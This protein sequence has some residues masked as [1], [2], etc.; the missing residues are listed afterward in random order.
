VSGVALSVLVLGMHRSGTSAISGALNILG[1]TVPGE[2]IPA[3]DDNPKGFFE[4]KTFVQF[5][6]RVLAR[7]DSRYDD[8]L[9]VAPDWRKSAV[10]RALTD[11][12]LLLAAQEFSVEPIVLV[13]DPRMCQFA[14]LWFDALA[15]L[16]RRVVCVLPGRHPLEVADSLRRRNQMSRP[17]ALML[18]LQ[19][20]LTA[21]RDT[22][23]SPRTFVL[24]EDLL[25]DWRGVVRKIASDLE[26]AWPRDVMR[27]QDEIDEFLQTDLRHHHHAG[28]RFD[29]H[30]P[31]H[32]M[33]ARVWGA[34]QTLSR[35]AD[36][37]G[38]LAAFDQAADAL[39][40]AV[41][42]FGPLLISAQRSQQRT[43]DDL[44]A[45]LSEMNAGL[46]LHRQ[47]LADRDQKL[48]ESQAYASTL[49]ED[50][51][52]R[53]RLLDAVRAA[54]EADR[55]Q[56]EAEILRLR[57]SAE[58][59]LDESRR[60][61]D[62]VRIDSQARLEAAVQAARAEA[63]RLIE[64]TRLTAHAELDQARAQAEQARAETASL[65]GESRRQLEAA[66][67]DGQARLE[68]SVQAVRAELE[69][70]QAE[71]DQA[72]AQAQW[73]AEESRRQLEAAWNDGQA[74]LE[75]SVQAVRVEAESLLERTSL[76][77]QVE[78]ER[79]RVQTER[80]RAQALSIAEESGRRLEA[81]RIDGR[82]RLEAAVQAAQ[83]EAESLL[84]RMRQ[85]AQ[86]ELEQARVQAEATISQLGLELEIERLRVQTQASQLATAEEAA[87]ARDLRIEM[88]NAAVLARDLEIRAMYNSASWKL[89]RPI[90]APLRLVLGEVALEEAVRRLGR[91]LFGRSWRPD[92]AAVRQASRRRGRA[93]PTAAEARQSPRPAIDRSDRGD[94]ESDGHPSGR[95]TEF[96]RRLMSPG[97]LAMLPELSE[98][99]LDHVD[100][101]VSVIIPTYN[102]GPELFWLIKKL[103]GQKGLNRVEIVIVDSG[104]S[105]GTPELAE[106]AGCTVV[107]I[108]KSDFS[109]SHARNIG[110]ENATGDLLLFTVQDA[111]P[112]GDHWLQT[113]GACLLRPRGEE[114][115]LAALS[116]AEFPRRDTELFYNALIDTHYKFIGCDTTDRIGEL[117][118][119]DS[120]S[121][122]SNGQLSDIACLIPRATFEKYHYSGRYAEDLLLGI[123]LIRDG[124]K[125]GLLSSVKVI[126]SH[127]RPTSYHVRRVFVDV[128]FLT[129]VFPD[130]GVPAAS[131]VLGAAACA[132][133]LRA[134]IARWRPRPGCNAV[135]VLDALI[136]E[137]GDF[138]TPTAAVSLNGDGFGFAPLAAWIADFGPA[139]GGEG[140][141]LGPGDLTDA[142]QVRAMFIDR[143]LNIRNY[144]AGVY[145]VVDETLAE[146]IKDAV[147]KTLAMTL[148]AQLAFI[149][150]NEQRY[151]PAVDE[152][153]SALRDILL[154]GI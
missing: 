24:Y 25:N 54:A 43:L 11:E 135:E 136:T 112:I 35:D 10:G 80:A 32:A 99:P 154:E 129:E 108:A 61:L 70:A 53:E 87:R 71:A 3:G 97:D 23:G 143:L 111:Y 107:R 142:A 9:P 76:T 146:E 45:R 31:L 56:A 141:P 118:G 100:A 133:A 55:S 127:N 52:E 123:R 8:F 121:L 20:V 49:R 102:A 149:Y 75:A 41:D 47:A 117:H 27:V 34:F 132:Y 96:R 15:R 67:A 139:P 101:S 98:E 122:R 14:P 152:R 110:A 94:P 125:I 113:L 85:S 65:A 130:F 104:S 150:L 119:L 72:R 58:A 82:S 44:R 29:A 63:E 114:Q 144:V 5:H 90:R 79:A 39:A 12:L 137:L 28:D 19:H 57:L 81:A 124:Y 93:L 151:S 13:K 46:D 74:R 30:D 86:V 106:R 147:E 2:Q 116:C 77:A 22:R 33:C 38:A 6:D 88:A 91:V 1:A 153:L 115:R 36:D 103:T 16:N 145:T 73:T 50:L 64:Q 60:Q 120:T 7:L 59:D 105:D 148:G 92:S 62:A 95:P 21:E 109:H 17:Q 40:Q 48:S 128:V 138:A 69:Q 83:A 37:K 66:Q 140:S 18:W 126:H 134:K 4:S 68:A 131:S 89:L 84:E 42:L 78:L 51:G 26:I